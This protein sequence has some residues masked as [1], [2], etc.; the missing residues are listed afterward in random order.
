MGGKRVSHSRRK[1]RAG[2]RLEEEA[3]R[4]E[5]GR[6]GGE[7]GGR[8]FQLEQFQVRVACAGRLETRRGQ[9]CFKVTLQAPTPGRRQAGWAPVGTAL[10]SALRWTKPWEPVRDPR[11]SLFRAPCLPACPSPCPSPCQGHAS[12]RSGE[13]LQPP[14][15]HTHCLPGNPKS[16]CVGPSELLGAPGEARDSL[17]WSVHSTSGGDSGLGPPPAAPPLNKRSR[18]W[19]R[20]RLS[21]RGLEAWSARPGRR[22]PGC[23]PQA[24]QG[25][26]M[27][28]CSQPR[29]TCREPGRHPAPLPR[30]PAASAPAASFIRAEAPPKC[31]LTQPS[32]CLSV[33]P[34]TPQPGASKEHLG[35]AGR[36]G[37]CGLSAAAR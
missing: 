15:Q 1:R 18:D 20:W 36:G 3:E 29:A 28:P 13:G 10:A 34:L 14:P 35:P 9:R 23:S 32:V 16:S 30:P 7:A 8:S 2:L 22:P 5:E 26:L 21:V 24:T 6:G 37:S 31:P 27:C 19:P 17:C 25:L 12:Q 4:R 11:A 33:R